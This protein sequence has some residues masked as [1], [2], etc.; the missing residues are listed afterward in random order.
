MFGSDGKGGARLVGRIKIE[1]WA[2]FSADVHE[3]HEG[4]E[5]QNYERLP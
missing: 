4:H 5:E 3:D 1:E 2:A